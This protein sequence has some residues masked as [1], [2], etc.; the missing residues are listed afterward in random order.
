[1]RGT[2]TGMAVDVELRGLRLRVADTA[3][4]I[5]G[6]AAQPVIVLLHGLGA[7]RHDWV[8]VTPPLVARG[9]RVVAPDL[10]GHGDS[11]RPRG[12]YRPEVFA[13]DVE[14][15]LEALAIEHYVVV[16]H[17][18]GGAV[19]AT[20]AL[21]RPSGLRGLV[22]ANSVPAFNPRRP[23]EHFEIWLRLGVTALL[24]PAMLG[25]IMAQR[26]YPAPEQARLRAESIARAAGNS[27]CVYIS[28]LYNLTR[29]SADERLGEIAVPTLVLAGDRDYFEVADVCRYAD[30]IPGAECRVLAGERHAMPREAGERVAAAIAEF[31]SQ[32]MKA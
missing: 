32:R 25:R 16:G 28:S 31:C 19:A 12:S 26:L 2:D 22:I 3:P 24:G 1:M 27:R 13:D 18:M 17:S 23:R 15:L 30:G 11:Q 5:A 4:G 7:S 14:A 20:L 8:T 9:Y 21:R 10:R 29:W 6:T